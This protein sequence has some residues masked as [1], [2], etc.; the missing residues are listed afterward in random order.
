M[1]GDTNPAHLNDLGNFTEVAQLESILTPWKGILRGL[2][3]MK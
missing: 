2:L 1:K 3:F